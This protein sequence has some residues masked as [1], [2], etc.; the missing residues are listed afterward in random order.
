MGQTHLNA[1]IW[2]AAI[3]MSKYGPLS[4]GNTGYKLIVA[5]VYGE[6]TTTVAWNMKQSQCRLTIFMQQEWICHST[7]NKIIPFLI[8]F[9]DVTNGLLNQKAHSH[10]QTYLCLNEYELTTIILS[11][12]FE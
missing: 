9:Q 5:S 12:T 6:I 1:S 10:L 4:T 3:T 7:A 11:D 2:E 8:K